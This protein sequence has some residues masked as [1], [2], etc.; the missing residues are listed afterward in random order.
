MESRAK[1][2]VA[3][4]PCKSCPYRQDVPSGV[5]A[6]EEYDKLPRYDGEIIEQIAGGG[7]GLFMCH[8]GDGNLCAGW[9]ACHGP[10][11]LAAL[12]LQGD[13][14][15]DDVWDYTTTVPVFSSGAE[16]ADHGRAE[17]AAPSGRARRTIERLVRNRV[18]ARG[19]DKVT[20]LT[21]PQRALLEALNEEPDMSAECA[22]EL[23]WR[24]AKVLISRGLVALIGDPPERASVGHFFEA[25]I[26]DAGRA[27]LSNN[28]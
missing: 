10:H 16:A 12:R 23:E 18:S 5:W 1:A 7:A 22:A 14:V 8:Q 9:L 17:I 2:S 3:A 25:Q 15:N 4:A 21:K 28:T 11:N 13:Q 24:P 6:A 27:A 20:K 26:T 19:E